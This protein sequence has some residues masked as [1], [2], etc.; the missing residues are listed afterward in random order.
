MTCAWPTIS[1]LSDSNRCT[2][3]VCALV[4]VTSLSMFDWMGVSSSPE[5]IG[6]SCLISAMMK[7]LRRD[8]CTNTTEQRLSSFSSSACKFSVLGNSALHIRLYWLGADMC[9]AS[10]SPFNSSFDNGHVLSNSELSSSF[11]RK[12]SNGSIGRCSYSNLRVKSS[13]INY[14]LSLS[15]SGLIL[16]NFV[17]SRPRKVFQLSLDSS[18]LAGCKN[19]IGRFRLKIAGLNWDFSSFIIVELNLL[20]PAISS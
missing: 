7:L 16:N 4:S 9:V 18:F 11:L 19:S 2:G 8:L 5:R 12:S 14:F 3:G 1:L 20:G 10:F 15:I 13:A 6:Y 17:V